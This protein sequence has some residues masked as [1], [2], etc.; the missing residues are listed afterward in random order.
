LVTRSEPVLA[1]AVRLVY[2]IAIY[3]V[4]FSLAL[5][6]PAGAAVYYVD[7]NHPSASDTN[8]GS[9]SQP[10]A[11]I[12]KANSTLQAGDTVIIKAG[13]YESR[14]APW[15]SG[16]PGAYI[17]YQRYEDDLVVLSGASLEPGIWLYNKSYVKVDGI[18]LDWV[19]KHAWIQYGSDHNIIRNCHFMNVVSGGGSTSGILIERDSDYNQLLDSVLEH[20]GTDGGDT[21]CI[22]REATHNLIQ[23]SSVL[24]GG[25]ACWAIRG[26]SFNILRDNYFVNPSQKI[27]EVYD[28]VTLGP[29][30]MTEHN[31]IEGNRFDYIPKHPDR[32]PYSGIQFCGQNTIIR[33][34]RFY[35]ECGPGLRL[36][37]WGSGSFPEAG[38][39]FGNRIY[40]NVFYGNRLSGIITCAVTSVEIDFS[41]NV[42]K[43][44]ILS[45][46]WYDQQ[47]FRSHCPLYFTCNGH[48]IQFKPGRLDGYLFE[49]N[50][51]YG[52][53]SDWV[54]VGGWRVALFE[55]PNHDLA[56]WEANH[57]ALFRDNVQTDPQFLD[58]P[59]WDFHLTGGSPMIDAGAHL[60]AV[61]ADS[62]GPELLV[63]DAKYFCDGFGIDGVA[64]DVIR[65]EGSA[66][67]ARVLAVDYGTNTLTLDR[68]VSAVVGQGV[69]LDY[70]G[71]APDIGAFEYVSPVQVVG[72]YV[73][74]NNSDWDG[75]G[76]AAN[77]DDDGAIAPDKQA[78]LPGG[79]A[80]FANY[81]SYARGI[82]G[83]MIDVDGLAGTPTVGDFAF[84]VGND[85]TPDDWTV[86]TD[87]GISVSLRAGAGAGGADRVTII[88]PDNL[89][90]NQWL[91]VTMLATAE[92]GLDSAD[93]FY[94]GNAIGETGDN[95]ADARVTPTDVVRVRDNPRT[96][97]QNPA[98]VDSPY[99]F[100][101]DRNVGPADAILARDHGSNSMTALQ[102]ITVP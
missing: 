93:V 83:I 89:V 102:L 70:L 19:H 62:S 57:P 53:E 14:I 100:N 63:A 56:W 96:I 76:P 54:I 16:A 30:V 21:I 39:D 72:R 48:T 32:S 90:E 47:D 86:L 60:T 13:T 95:P 64:G 84:K 80:T 77:A 99:D 4:I 94:F 35:D 87:P 81:T 55:P 23:G 11:T 74:Y 8:P 49:N 50:C 3:G 28:S 78:L 68:P 44:N 88:L 29:S 65:L 61:A 24:E 10:W 22:R 6:G 5:A 25:H 75:W 67:T 71:A 97:G 20:A 40:H 33:R 43:N 26:S 101:R 51:V 73:F 15:R 42:I 1:A 98:A 9:E 59:N 46:N 91:Q 38:R 17:T 27:A 41:D 34:N 37:I 7:R 36:G 45:E 58:A 52:S 31:V 66:Q 2:P 85:E 18:T 92:T 79:T 82:N 69:S 12:A